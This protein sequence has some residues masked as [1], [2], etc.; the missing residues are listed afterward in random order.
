MIYTCS[1]G[2]TW[3]S[4]AFKAYGDEFLFPQIMEE[5]RDYADVVTFEGGE[6]IDIPDRLV[7]E[8]SIIATPWETGAKIGIIKAPWG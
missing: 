5:N 6:K 3:D 4:V 8:N 7:V 1:Q 2:D